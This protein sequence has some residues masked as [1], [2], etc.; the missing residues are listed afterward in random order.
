MTILR[1][2]LVVRVSTWSL[3]WTAQAKM[4][5]DSQNPQQHASATTTEDNGC[6]V[7]EPSC[8]SV[9]R[10][11]ITRSRF[12]GSASMAGMR[13]PTYWIVLRNKCQGRVY[14]RACLTRRNGSPGC[15]RFGIDE[16]KGRRYGVSGAS[17]PYEVQYWGSRRV[18]QDWV[19]RD[20][21]PAGRLSGV[22]LAAQ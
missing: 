16:G 6:F 7:A 2:F 17:G 8:L 18:S 20:T 5:E 19:C 14:V 22:H 12:E 9:S 4:P 13:D 21:Y 11:L 10:Q 15:D 1:W 3:V